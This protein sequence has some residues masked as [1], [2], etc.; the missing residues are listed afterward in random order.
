MIQVTAQMPDAISY[1]NS[2]SINAGVVVISGTEV[3][4]ELGLATKGKA[5]PEVEK[6]IAAVA[7]YGAAAN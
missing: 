6:L 4:Q 5:T 7:K 2:A 1:G 3:K